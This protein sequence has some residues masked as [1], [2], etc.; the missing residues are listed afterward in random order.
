MADT[1]PKRV[2]L[3]GGAGQLGLALQCG[4][5]SGIQL[6]VT[7]RRTLDICDA[8]AVATHLEDFRPSVLINAAAYTA[9]DLAET[10]REAA[11][12]ANATAPGVLAEVCARLDI[13]LLHVSTDFVFNGLSSSPYP[14]DSE[15]APLGVYGQS[16]LAGERAVVG[17]SARYA[18]VR[19]GWVYS[20]RGK[21]FLRTMLR[22]HSERE[23]LAVVDDQIGTPTAAHSLAA[24]LWALAARPALQGIY[25]WSDAGACSWYDFAV[26]IGEEAQALGLLA[27]PARVKPI[28]TSA[29]PTPARRPAYSVL[30]KS[31]SWQD[32]DLEPVHWRTQLRTTLKALQEINDG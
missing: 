7:D 13:R 6:K 25:H 9:V 28:A 4:V 8:A 22:L 31:R 20:P 26:A 21:N 18:I 17:A 12:S 1:L 23:Q 19:T 32:F 5:P 30:D 11:F 16:K 3:T 2:L 27:A 29:Y 24:A 15:T 14:P 10:E